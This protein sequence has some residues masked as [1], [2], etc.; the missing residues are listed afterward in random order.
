MIFV[1]PNL[2]VASGAFG[3]GVLLLVATLTTRR[4]RPHPLLNKGLWLAI[5]AGVLGY[6]LGGLAFAATLYATAVANRGIARAI[7]SAIE[8]GDRTTA[9]AW[10][11]G[12]SAL[13][14]AALA[15][16][17]LAPVFAYSD[18]AV[19]I[20]AVG[21]FWGARA[22][23]PVG[24]SFLAFQAVSYLADIYRGR[25]GAGNDF[26]QSATY[27]LLLPQFVAGPVRYENVSAQL[28][29]RA[30]GMS[31]FAYG[32]RRLAI[33]IGKRL[34]IAQ[35]CAMAANEIFGWRST[36]LTASAAWLAVLCLTIQI[37]FTFSG[38]ADMAIGLGRL[39][40]FRGEENFKWPYA[41]DSIHGFW[42]RWHIGLTSAFREY[43]GAALLGPIACEAAVV[44]LCAAWYGLSWSC[45]A[46]GVYH[47]V[48]LTLERLGGL[49]AA[50]VPWLLRHAYVAL[51]VAIGWVFLRA[52]TPAAALHM[53]K[54]MVTLDI[55][56]R[57]RPLP[58]S[59]WLWVGIV[60]GVVG[61]APVARA[62]KRWSVAIDGATTSMLMMLFA[63]AVFLWRIATMMRPR[64]GTAGR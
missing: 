20:G 59:L 30:V 21:G 61:S 49:R 28:S 47:L 10:L 37:Y 33:G 57:S 44:L 56:E 17:K 24:L 5:A 60:S 23:M 19:A 39:F 42:G 53:L 29:R 6:V 3:L 63:T 62:L 43:S 13:N 18:G 9:R 41:A 11:A 8:Q 1:R 26:T 58:M 7:A 64:N 16:M 54:T 31:D 25:A 15:W 48:F 51:V 45:L 12:G 50:R 27:L 40:G 55:P 14:V 38:Y 35:P 22:L 4:Q 36:D 2:L 32:V 52:A 34:L 46:W